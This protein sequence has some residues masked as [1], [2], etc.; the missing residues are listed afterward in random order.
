MLKTTQK[1]TISGMSIIDD[2]NVAEYSAQID[3]ENP[4]NMTLSNWQN[5]KELYKVNRTACRANQAGFEDLAYQKQD[6]L[7]AAKTTIEGGKKDEAK[8]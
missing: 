2:V 7:I 1:I 3:S 8:K 6:E 4:E 5:N